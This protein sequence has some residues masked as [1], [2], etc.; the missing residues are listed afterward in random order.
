MSLP[1]AEPTGVSLVVPVRNEEQRLAPFVTFVGPLLGHCLGGGLVL[2]QVVVV[3]DGSTD[4]T[5][6][7]LETLAARPGWTVVSASQSGR[8]K[9]DAVARGARAATSRLLL[10]CDVDLAAPLSEVTKLAAALDGG[11]AIAIGSRDVAGSSVTAPATRKVIGR[12]FNAFVRVTTGLPNRDTQCGFKL[13]TVDLARSLLSSLL[14]P[15]LAFDV[16]LLMRARL[17]G[18]RVAEVPIT[19][20][21]GEQSRVRPVVHGTAMGRDVL[22]LAYHLRL[23]PALSRRRAETTA[24][25]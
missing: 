15:G 7:Q 4:A 25:T 16:E 8:G 18:H 5:A 2:R 24:P 20:R 12:G 13:M 10:L 22:R 23:A 19:Y 14:V 3:D 6:S 21:H 9:G 11:A 17:G 1:G